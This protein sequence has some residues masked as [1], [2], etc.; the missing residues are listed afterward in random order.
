MT[1]AAASM[2]TRAKEAIP[3]MATRLG[4][5][6]SNFTFRFIVAFTWL[7]GHRKRGTCSARRLD[8]ADACILAHLRSCCSAESNRDPLPWACLK[9][10][11]ESLHDN[12]G[13]SRSVI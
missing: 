11:P 13:G 5:R 8:F 6:M 9:V 4:I 2:E 1:S 12:I 7:Q 3:T 10:T